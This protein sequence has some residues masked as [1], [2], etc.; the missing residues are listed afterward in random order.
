MQSQQQQL[1]EAYVFLRL[2]SRIPLTN[3]LVT[4]QGNILFEIRPM[5]FPEWYQFITQGA[6]DEYL[7]NLSKDVGFQIKPETYQG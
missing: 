2:K 1:E 4:G 3:Q 5:P 6:N 7:R